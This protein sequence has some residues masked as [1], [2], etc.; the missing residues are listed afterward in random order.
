MRVGLVLD[1]VDETDLDRARQAD[2]LGLWAVAVGGRPGTEAI[3]AARVAE[4]TEV[5]RIVVAVDVA[6][7]HPFTIAEEISVLDNLAA[8]RVV[9]IARGNPEA[10]YRD[11]GTFRGA[12]IG[13]TVNGVLVTPPPVQTAVPVWDASGT[14]G[15]KDESIV[16]RSIDELRRHGG[17]PVPGLVELS[18]DLEV[19]R[20]TIDLWRDEGC[21][22]LL[23]EWPGDVR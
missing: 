16:A 21:T 15:S 2:Q 8:G 3:R 17:Q 1:S 12:L 18:G 10:K 19:D 22:H 11:L 4:V 9:V 13:R 7:E 20:A 5:V 14:R 6:A 23:V